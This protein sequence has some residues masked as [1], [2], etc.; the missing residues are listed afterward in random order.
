METLKRLNL[1]LSFLLELLLALAAGYCAYALPLTM[2][3]RVGLA[4]LV[5]AA[6]IVI[7][8]LL[9]AP[10][11]LTRL[12]TPRLLMAKLTLFGGAA[13]AL[14]A[15]GRPGLTATFGVLILVNMIGVVAW[16]Q[17]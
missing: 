9:L 14:Y 6:L 13:L 2:A 12:S 17:F 7:W 15:A 1:G 8:S 10:K 16:K 4:I 3:L 5:P 11:A